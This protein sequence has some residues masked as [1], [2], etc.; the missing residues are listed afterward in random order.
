MIGFFARYAGGEVAVDG[1]EIAEAHWFPRD[2]LPVLPPR[3]SIARRLID[4]W[5]AGPA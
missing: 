3:T 5:R 2:G 4:A 1:S